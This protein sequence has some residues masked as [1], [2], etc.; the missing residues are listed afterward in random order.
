MVVVYFVASLVQGVVIT[1][2]DVWR[3]VCCDHLHYCFV[4][5]SCTGLDDTQVCQQKGLQV[6]IG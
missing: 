1:K 3:S 5:Y 4:L 2:I 6:E